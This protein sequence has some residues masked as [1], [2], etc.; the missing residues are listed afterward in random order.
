[1]EN[2]E[3]E[4]KRH[5]CAHI[6]A[7]AVQ[8]LFPGTKLGIGPA[9][10]NGFYYDFDCN[11][12]SQNEFEKIE[13]KMKEIIKRGESF[14]RQELSKQEALKLFKDEQYKIEL[15]RLGGEE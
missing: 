12:L 9:I 1:M 14:K 3:L 15:K 10:D 11:N 8:Q 13:N 6:M 4:T 2:N 7:A 5:S